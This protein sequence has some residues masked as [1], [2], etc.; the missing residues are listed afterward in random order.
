MFSIGTK[1]PADR[2]ARLQVRFEALQTALAKCTSDFEAWSSP[3]KADE[4]RGYAVAR[5]LR[6]QDVLRVYEGEA[7]SYLKSVGIK[8]RPLYAGPSPLAGSVNQP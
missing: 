3:G 5:I 6:V 4:V 1:A 7:H 2:R 8:V